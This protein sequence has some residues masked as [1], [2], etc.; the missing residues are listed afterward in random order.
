MG[1]YIHIHFEFWFIQLI[2]LIQVLNVIV[3]PIR[4]IFVPVIIP[5]FIPT[6]YYVPVYIN[7]YVHFYVP[8]ASPALYIDVH[9]EVISRPNHT[10]QYLVT[11]QSGESVDDATVTVNY[12]GTDY[13]TSFIANG[14]Y[15]VVLP[16]SDETE[17]VEVT[18][19]KDWYPDGS[20]IYDLNA[21]G[22]IDV[23]TQEGPL[24]L[25]PVIA[26]LVCLAIGTIFI[27]R[28]K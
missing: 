16:M 4:F 13:V 28:K 14:V 8:Y 18:A 20:L 25:I 5:V 21:T 10:I 7:N 23:V 19:Q 22:I 1:D 12:N 2:F 3:N 24:S 11:D 6:I 15:E 26:S 17:T 9:D 27:K